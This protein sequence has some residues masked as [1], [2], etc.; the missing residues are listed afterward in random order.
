M[1]PH[2]S[3]QSIGRFFR[4]ATISSVWLGGTT[5]SSADAV[6]QLRHATAQ[7][8]LI[9][10][11]ARR[12]DVIVG[13]GL[14]QLHVDAHA[15]EQEY[16]VDGVTESLKPPTSRASRARSSSAGARPSPTRAGPSI[17]KTPARLFERALAQAR[18]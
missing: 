9:D 2:C 16:F 11:Q 12:I 1:A 10:V 15:P 14:D 4:A 17:S 8:L 5:L 3:D 13:L 18:G 7:R 6:T